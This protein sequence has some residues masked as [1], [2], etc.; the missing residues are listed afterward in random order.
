MKFL[1]LKAH[2]S[3]SSTETKTKKTLTIYLVYV[4]KNSKY[5]KQI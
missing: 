1:K 5:H 3:R 4:K 2:I